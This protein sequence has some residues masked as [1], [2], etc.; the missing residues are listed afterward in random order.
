MFNKPKKTKEQLAG[1]KEYRTF[2]KLKKLRLVDD[3]FD[4]KD[5]E[6][7]RRYNDF[8][9]HPKIKKLIDNHPARFSWYSY[10]LK[11]P[12][13]NDDY[14]FMNWVL[15]KDYLMEHYIG[16]DWGMSQFK[17]HEDFLSRKQIHGMI[18][19]KIK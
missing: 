15:A 10:T 12:C 9:I 19:E 1:D 5:K 14:E 18:L 6:R 17:L 13:H 3:I 16:D 11:G 4:H 8:K 2:T 7:D